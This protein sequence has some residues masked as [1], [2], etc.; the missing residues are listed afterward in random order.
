M[1]TDKFSQLPPKNS[2]ETQAETNDT[3]RGPN[4]AVAG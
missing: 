1:Y 2:S 3:S 4:N